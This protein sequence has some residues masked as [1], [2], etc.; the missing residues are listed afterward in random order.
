MES[1]LFGYEDGA[2]TG[3]KKGGKPGRFEL[4]LNGTLSLDDI[5]DMPPFLQAKLLRVLQERRIE[6][7]GGS[8]SI[9]VD[10]RLIAA[11]HRD[12]E[13]MIVCGQCR[14]DLF[15]RLDVIPVYVP[16]LRNRREDLYD[17]IQFT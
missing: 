4:A 3:A 11:T 5:G 7:I 10:T 15:Y 9:P 1:E 12:L 6:R 13:S 2:F 16:G 14:E 17:L 8:E